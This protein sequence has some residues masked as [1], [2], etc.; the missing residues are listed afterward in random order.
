M[1]PGQPLREP[2]TAGL[3]AQ[4]EIIKM[5]Q[6]NRSPLE[7]FAPLERFERDHQSRSFLTLLCGQRTVCPGLTAAVRYDGLSGMRP[8]LSTRLTALGSELRNT[9]STTSPTCPHDIII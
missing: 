1:A 9:M 3:P 2:S 4:E 8:P 7:R 6:H 5:V